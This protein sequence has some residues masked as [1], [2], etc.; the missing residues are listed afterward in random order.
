MDAKFV[1]CDECLMGS[2]RLLELFHGI[3]SQIH[4]N[5]RPFGG[6]QC[7]VG[8]WLQLKPVADKFDDGRPMYLSVLFIPIL[9][10]TYNQADDSASAERR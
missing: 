1:V 5:L 3:T 7:I 6:M 2:A 8:D 4:G 9:V 10:P